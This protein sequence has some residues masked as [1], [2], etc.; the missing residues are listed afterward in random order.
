MATRAWRPGNQKAQQRRITLL[1]RSGW[2]GGLW[3]AVQASVR[4]CQID[5]LPVRHPWA[6]RS[7]GRCPLAVILYCGVAS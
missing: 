7:H 6:S 4:S 1:P 3:R 2:R 5:L